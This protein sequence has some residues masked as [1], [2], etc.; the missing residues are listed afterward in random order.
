MFYFKRV[1]RNIVNRS[2]ITHVL[3]TTLETNHAVGHV[4]LTQTTR[5]KKTPSRT[6]PVPL[7]VPHVELNATI[8]LDVRPDG[9]VTLWLKHCAF[10]GKMSEWLRSLFPGHVLLQ[11]EVHVSVVT[12]GLE[13]LATSSAGWR[14]VNPCT[15]IVVTI[16]TT[17][18][19]GPTCGD[20]AS[21]DVYVNDVVD[22][23]DDKLWT[24]TL[25][26]G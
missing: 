11:L 16:R 25:V 9:G 3:Q 4:A 13:Y 17:I 2:W 21:S 1:L 26:T 7:T 20:M 5:V 18:T 14:V 19:H 24:H 10:F 12:S 8:L 22:G 15:W 23:V 6:F